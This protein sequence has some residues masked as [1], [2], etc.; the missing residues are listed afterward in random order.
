VPKPYSNK[1]RYACGKSNEVVIHGLSKIGMVELYDFTLH[2]F[3][4]KQTPVESCMALHICFNQVDKY[5]ANL[6]K[7]SYFPS[8]HY[9]NIAIWI[10]CH[11][12]T[13]LRHQ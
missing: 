10:L 12:D 3:D 7:T 8:T 5:D 9:F 11:A 1:R 6:L 2:I 13:I 4:S